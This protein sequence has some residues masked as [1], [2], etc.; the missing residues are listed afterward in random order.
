MTASEP[1]P[2]LC[3]RCGHD[4]D[5]HDWENGCPD[6]ELGSLTSSR[7]ILKPSDIAHARL[8]AEPTE[9]EVKDSMLAIHRELASV[10]MT[11]VNAL[12]GDQVQYEAL[13]RGISKA[14]FEAVKEARR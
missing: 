3:H 1:A 4:I 6:C 12:D 5:I 10:W 13:L 11:V 8:T 14:S 2:I 7:C 9:V